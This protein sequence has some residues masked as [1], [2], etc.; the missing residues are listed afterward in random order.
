M[1]AIIITLP[2]HTHIPVFL[3]L[4]SQAPSWITGI[5]IPILRMRKLWHRE[6]KGRALRLW[7]LISAPF[8]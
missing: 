1:A 4:L 6:A 2:P 7:E 8:Q 3:N 5:V